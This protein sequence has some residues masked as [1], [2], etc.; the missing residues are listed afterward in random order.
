[1]LALGVSADAL[2]SPTHLTALSLK[3]SSEQWGFHGLHP[4]GSGS[5]V[6]L[7]TSASDSKRPMYPILLLCG[8][9]F[10]SSALLRSSCSTHCLHV[11]LLEPLNMTSAHSGTQRQQAKESSAFPVLAWEGTATIPTTLSC[12]RYKTRWQ[13]WSCPF[14]PPQQGSLGG[15][16]KAPA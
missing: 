4:T 12:Q 7:A 16:R 3:Y 5:R 8:K 14:Y 10:S 2:Y 15:K 6:I 11:L 13:L 1:M 9:N